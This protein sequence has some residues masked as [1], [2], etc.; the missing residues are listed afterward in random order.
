MSYHSIDTAIFLGKFLFS[1]V[2]AIVTTVVDEHFLR[3]E[4]LQILVTGYTAEGKDRYL[5]GRFLR[6]FRIL[7]ARRIRLTANVSEGS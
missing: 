3:N 5:I 6:H 2:V 1:L 7:G 4:C